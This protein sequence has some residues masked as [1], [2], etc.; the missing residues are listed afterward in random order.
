MTQSFWIRHLANSATM[1]KID[2]KN[3]IED[4]RYQGETATIIDHVNYI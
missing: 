1:L 2:F 3:A 4:S